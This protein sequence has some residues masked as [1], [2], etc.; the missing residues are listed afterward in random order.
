MAKTVYAARFLSQRSRPSG[1]LNRIRYAANSDA[2]GLAIAQELATAVDGQLVRVSKYL[3]GPEKPAERTQGTGW[4]ASIICKKDELVRTY[5]LRNILIDGSHTEGAAR[6]AILAAFSNVRIGNGTVV[7][8]SID[9]N[10]RPT[11]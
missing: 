8:D 2:D 3:H 4:S 5:H 7:P 11:R 6:T 1:E 10:I 9:V